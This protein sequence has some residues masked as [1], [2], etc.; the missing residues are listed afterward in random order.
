MNWFSPAANF[1]WDRD[2]GA[3]LDL[4]P[5]GG[6]GQQERPLHT[7][8][9]AGETPGVLEITDRDL[10]AFEGRESLGVLP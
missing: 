6:V 5:L 9:G 1:F 4:C 8:E 7:L 10:G 2:Q 3:L